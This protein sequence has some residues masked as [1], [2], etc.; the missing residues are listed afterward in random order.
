[1]KIPGFT[2]EASLAPA[3]GQYCAVSFAVP[4]GEGS[5]A[6]AGFTDFFGIGEKESTGW[7]F[8]KALPGALADT[9]SSGEAYQSFAQGQHAAVQVLTFGAY[10]DPEGRARELEALGYQRPERRTERASRGVG[11]YVI[12][13][14]VQMAL[15][16]G[17]WARLG[18]P[19][20]Q[21][22]W[23]SFGLRGLVRVGLPGHAYWGIE[24]GVAVLPKARWV[25]AVG[26][27]FRALLTVEE[28]SGPSSS[29]WIMKGIPVLFPEAVVATGGT[30]YTCITA[31]VTGFLKGWIPG[32]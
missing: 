22:A 4:T 3:R 32:W 21:V 6:P 17:L 18:G 5:V 7:A 10:G 2:G 14:A 29:A 13:P 19:T 9:F 8:L 1:M 31:V 11:T 15:F 16:S 23:R 30:A 27:V 26:D 12:G 20:M 28:V 25:H 24:A